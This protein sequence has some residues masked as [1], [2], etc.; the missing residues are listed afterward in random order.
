MTDVFISY[1]RRNLPL[2]E[3]IDAVL[4]ARGKH[5]WFDKKKEPLEGIPPGSKWWDEIKY[6]IA[7]ADNFLFVISPESV[8]SPYCN[9]EIAYALQQ[10]KRIVTAFYFADRSEIVMR[11]AIDAAIDAIDGSQV[12]PQVVSAPVSNLRLLTRQNWL[13]LSEVQYVSFADGDGFDRSLD[14]LANAL[15]LDLAW[16]RTLSQLRQAAQIWDANGRD[17]DYRWGENRL[18]PMRQTIELKSLEVGDLVQAFI[19]PEQRRLYRELLDEKT[20]Y[21]RRRDIGDRLS[22]IGIG[23]EPAFY[24]MDVRDGV[25][26]ICWLPVVVPENLRDKPIIFKDENHKRYG[27]FVLESF[28]IAK[29]LITLVQF[30]TFLDADDGLRNLTWWSDFPE[31]YQLQEMESNQTALCYNPRDSVSWYQG[32]AFSRWLNHRLRGVN[33]GT[34][35]GT[36]TSVGEPPV[37]TIGENAIVRLPTEWE[38]QWA[39][40]NGVEERTYPWGRAPY[41]WESFPNGRANIIETGLRRAIAVGLYPQGIASCG[42][43]DMAGNLRE[44]CLNDHTNPTIVDGYGNGEAKAL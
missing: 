12:L 31:K 8:V 41:V 18:K 26:D 39:A 9:A 30:E 28:Y 16:V 43:L 38:W 4:T 20:D 13:A 42:A 3:Q 24:G 14:E 37:L 27:D 44:W 33:V 11:Q 10:Q 40:Q 32:V 21:Q 22:V 6:G 25:P 35:Y 34:G 17:E 2:I 7:N 15:D 23:D 5:V 19:E 36:D 29:H 1:S